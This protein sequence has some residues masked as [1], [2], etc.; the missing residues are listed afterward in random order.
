M[1]SDKVVGSTI[2]NN[3]ISDV[4]TEE[5]ET[6]FLRKPGIK[7]CIYLVKEH[8]RN[9][10]KSVQ[11]VWEDTVLGKTRKAVNVK[12]RSIGDGRN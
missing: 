1:E 10:K 11:R 8:F 6:K 3:M 12:D 9:E 7:P 5:K 2:L 4:L